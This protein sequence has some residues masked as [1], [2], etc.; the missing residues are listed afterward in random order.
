M[1]I[2]SMLKLVQFFFY[3]IDTFLNICI[4]YRVDEKRV[5]NTLQAICIK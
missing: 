2:N 3:D 5:S 1:V 4:S